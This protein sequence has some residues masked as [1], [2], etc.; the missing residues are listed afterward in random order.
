MPALFDSGERPSVI[1]SAPWLA[2]VSEGGVEHQLGGSVGGFPAADDL[3]D[4]PALAFGDGRG[5]DEADG[6]GGELGDVDPAA[7]QAMEGV[8]LDQEVERRQAPGPQP[9][10]EDPLQLRIAGRPF[11]APQRH[12]DALVA[13]TRQLGPQRGLAGEDALPRARIPHRLGTEQDAVERTAL[14]ELP[15]QP[16]VGGEI[17]GLLAARPAR[18]LRKQRPPRPAV[19]A[20]RPARRRPPGS[21]RFPRSPPPRRLRARASAEFPG[22]GSGRR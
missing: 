11:L 14:R 2:Q 21:H 9:F 6:L 12:R 22:S 13:G 17:A 4:Q 15:G 20:R 7:F 18:E 10:L 16:F 5:D 3:L 8:G 1:S 19:P